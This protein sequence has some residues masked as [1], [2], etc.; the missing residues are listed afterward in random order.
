MPRSLH[1]LFAAL[2]GSGDDPAAA[3]RAAGFGDVP[4]HLVTEAIVHYAGT[5]PLEVAE[6]LAPFAVAHGPV[7]ALDPVAASTTLHGGL[8]LLASAPPADAPF[9]DH[10]APDGPVVHDPDDHAG[11]GV[12][13]LDVDPSALDDDG[14]AHPVVQHPAVHPDAAHGP[15]TGAPH[16]PAADHGLGSFGVGHAAL[17]PPD[18]GPGAEAADHP[19]D[20]FP[21]HVHVQ[22]VEVHD[23]GVSD[24]HPERIDDHDTHDVHDH[25]PTWGPDPADLDDDGP[26]HV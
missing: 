20:P 14:S 22:D 12:G 21:T 5:A 9:V 3:L 8:T 13:H 26:H 11:D 15:A 2:G 18:D 23:H 24:V 17:S 6:H 10:D 1:E 16:G 19:A 4:D 25:D 7:P